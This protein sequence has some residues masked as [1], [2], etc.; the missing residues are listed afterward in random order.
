MTYSRRLVIWI[1]LSSFFLIINFYRLSLNCDNISVGFVCPSHWWATPKRFKI[2]KRILHH[3]IIGVDLA[4]L[5]GGRMASAEGGSVSSRMA[6]GEGCPLS[7]QLRGLGER[8]E[9]PQRGPGQSP[10]RKRILAYFEGHRTLIFVPKW[11]NLGGHFALASPHSKFWGDLSPLS[12][13][14]DLRPCS[15]RIALPLLWSY[16]LTSTHVYT[17]WYYSY[18]VHSV[19]YV[20]TRRCAL[21][22]VLKWS[23]SKRTH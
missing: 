2:S 8:R 21:Y 19:N 10:G 16:F 18:I 20:Y 15:R 17:P 1:L 4:G 23:P 11:Q 22:Y 7:S 12:P 14:R 13:P 9:L 3:M 5:L 6:C